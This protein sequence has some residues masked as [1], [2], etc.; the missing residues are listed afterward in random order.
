MASLSRLGCALAALLF[1]PTS[2]VIGQA[3]VDL[4]ALA[5]SVREVLRV[6]Y[7]ERQR[8]SYIEQ[9]RDIDVSMLG[10]VSIGPMRTYEVYPLAPGDGWKR[11]IAVDGKPLDPGE[12]ARNDAEHERDLKKRAEETP[13][14]RA[15]RLKDRAEETRD[16]DAIL[17]DAYAVFQFAFICR[18]EIDGH[19]VI[20]LSMTP[21]PQARV[22]TREGGYMKQF[23]GRLWVSEP[24]HHIARVQLR[25]TDSV[26][27]GWG[28]VARVEP[29][30]GFDLV[31]KKIGDTWVASTLTVEGSGRTLM[32][33]RFEVKT[34]TT[35]S[36]HRPYTPPPGT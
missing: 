34:V 27:V 24:D 14:Q 32:F 16:R 23:T 35:Y 25:A 15:A 12:L 13:K 30:S 29:G 19:P 9:G 5:K 33:R 10:K 11:L 26:S 6:E 17:D 22:K 3:P 28:V 1:L 4:D 8:F 2:S 21:R 31:R 18:E 7:S 20:A 36:Q